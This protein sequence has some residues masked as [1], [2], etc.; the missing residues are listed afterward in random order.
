V[1]EA[2][3]M[4]AIVLDEPV[5]AATQSGLWRQTAVA[6]AEPANVE[7]I[8]VRCGCR[9]RHEL[10][11][12]LRGRRVRCKSCRE[13]MVVRAARRRGVGDGETV[14]TTKSR[15]KRGRFGRTKTRGNDE[16]VERPYQDGPTTTELVSAL[17]AAG[18]FVVL[19]CV[20]LLTCSCA[21]LARAPTPRRRVSPAGA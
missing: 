8:S 21:V 10:P 2:A 3:I 16:I 20:V 6:V 12:S 1:A 11:E 15:A 14:S 17:T 19:V 18:V 9:S 4:G 5:A 13:L 7:P